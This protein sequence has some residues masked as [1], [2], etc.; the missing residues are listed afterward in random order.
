M[1]SVQ[2]SYPNQFLI[3]LLFLLVVFSG[4]EVGA[5]GYDFFDSNPRCNTMVNDAYKDMDYFNKRKI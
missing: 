1:M 5:R 2:V 3:F 4:I